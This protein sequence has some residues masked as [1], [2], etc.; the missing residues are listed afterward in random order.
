MSN[1]MIYEAFSTTPPQAQKEIKGGRLK[2]FTD[3]N[4][5][6]RIQAL[7]EQFGP[8]GI[9]WYYEVINRW[10]EP[11]AAGVVAAFVEVHLFYKHD[12]EWSKPV[13]GI[14]G[15]TFVAKESGGM[16]TSDE[17]FKMA[18]TDALSVAFK[19]LGGSADI[20]FSKGQDRTK[21][22]Y[23]QDDTPQKNNQNIQ[24]QVGDKPLSEAQ[25]KRLYAL[26]KNAGLTDEEIKQAPVTWFGKSARDLTKAEYDEM[27]KALEERP[28][29]IKAWIVEHVGG[30]S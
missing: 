14:G 7:T 30:V 15:N 19:A 22:N 24:G 27:C 29:D 10:T 5:M 26:S 3:I 9:G 16:H 23:R 17:C 20:Y 8:C 11:G 1:M 13:Y 28:A 2:G 21:Y 18:L 4:P 12:N 25:L 6:W